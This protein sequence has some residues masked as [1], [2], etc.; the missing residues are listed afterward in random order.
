MPVA[1]VDPVHAPARPVRGGFRRALP[2]G[3][4]FLLAAG[5]A[6]GCELAAGELKITVR[7]EADDGFWGP[8]LAIAAD[9]GVGPLNKYL[10]GESRPLEA[11]WWTR[12]DA[13][14][15]PALVI[16]LGPA[17]DQPAGVLVLDWRDGVWQPRRMPALPAPSNAF[18]Y[19]FLVQGGALRAIPVN[20]HGGPA[21]SLTA[22]QWAAD[23]W[24]ALSPEV[25]QSP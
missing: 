22:W 16:G 14:A 5:A 24:Q 4:L 3:L 1:G 18:D 10:A 8:T 20:R 15:D 19:R 23:G 11:C 17:T 9:D 21:P 6:C 7:R 13:A 12:L 25:L 2:A